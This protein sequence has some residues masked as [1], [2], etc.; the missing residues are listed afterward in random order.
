MHSNFSDLKT[1]TMTAKEYLLHI[2]F[3]DAHLPELFNNDD[4]SYYQITELMEKYHQSKLKLLGISNVVGQ[5][6][7]Y[8]C[9]KDQINQRCGEQCLGCY[10]Y[11]NDKV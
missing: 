4:K 3:D 8:F 1:K 10:M 9:C 11:V 2:G 5:S 7:Q 6:E